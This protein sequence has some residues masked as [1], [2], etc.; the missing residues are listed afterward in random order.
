MCLF[1]MNVL[2][3]VTVRCGYTMSSGVQTCMGQQHENL[4]TNLTVCSV[5]VTACSVSS[6]DVTVHW[7]IEG[8]ALPPP[9]PLLK[10][11]RV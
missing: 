5:D 1:Q 4:L 10:L 7:H 2:V 3:A 9:T 6:V 11:V 8:G